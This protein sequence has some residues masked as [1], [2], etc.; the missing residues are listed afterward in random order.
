MAARFGNK[1]DIQCYQ[2]AED[3]FT[4]EGGYLAQE[5]DLLDKNPDP[6]RID[7]HPLHA[8]S[9]M[10]GRYAAGVTALL[11]T[12]CGSAQTAAIRATMIPAA[13]AT[14]AMIRRLS[15]RPGA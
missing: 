10:L 4:S 7:R 11:T 12:A 13:S 15:S 5:H 3:A 9:K 8:F 1:S 6:A 2:S 14:E